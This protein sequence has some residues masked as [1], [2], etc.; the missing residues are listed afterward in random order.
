MP[1]SAL[2]AAVIA[3][4]VWWRAEGEPLAV[5]LIVLALAGL[6]V[7]LVLAWFRL[8]SNRAS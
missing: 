3:A 2:V 5:G 6:V 4:G 8:R 7:L 1:P